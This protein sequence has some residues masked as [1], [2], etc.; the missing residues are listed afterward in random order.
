MSWVYPEW[1]KAVLELTE[2][3]LCS[4]KWGKKGG[5]QLSERNR[6]WKAAEGGAEGFVTFCQQT[7]TQHTY[8]AVT[9]GC[10]PP[11]ES[12]IFCS[13]LVVH[14]VSSFMCCS[15]TRNTGVVSL[16]LVLLGWSVVCEQA[17][18]QWSDT[19][20]RACYD[21]QRNSKSELAAVAFYLI[22]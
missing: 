15:A 3:V 12:S 13:S 8:L 18:Q 14:L 22:F 10:P 11:G 21:L 16:Q 5:L 19:K 2:A 4:H 6:K 17:L 20:T 1:I 7:C 9:T